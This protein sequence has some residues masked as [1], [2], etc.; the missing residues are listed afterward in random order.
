[1]PVLPSPLDIESTPRP[2]P[3]VRL[4]H[5]VGLAFGEREQL[6]QQAGALS[7]QVKSLTAEIERLRQ[8]N[9]DLREA[10]AIWIRMYERQLSRANQAARR[11]AEDPAAAR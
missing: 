3:R 4:E 5:A 7:R 11:L 6:R 1:M 2:S 9:T 10:A 8:E